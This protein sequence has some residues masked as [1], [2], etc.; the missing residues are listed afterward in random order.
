MMRFKML[1]GG[2]EIEG[3]TYKELVRSMADKKMEPIHDLD[4][5]RRRT[6]QRV[7]EMFGHDIHILTNE[8]FVRDLEAHGLLERIDG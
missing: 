1:P 3:N 2:E 7:Q 4:G 5:Y 6:A 8:Q